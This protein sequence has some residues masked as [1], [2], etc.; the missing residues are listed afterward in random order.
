MKNCIE[1]GLENDFK[2]ILRSNFN[3]YIGKQIFN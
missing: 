2:I 1:K 3:E